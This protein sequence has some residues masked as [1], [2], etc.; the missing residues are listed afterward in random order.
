MLLWLESVET[1][2]INGTKTL[3]AILLH[4]VAFLIVYDFGVESV[5]FRMTEFSGPHEVHVPPTFNF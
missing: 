1:S 4:G 5:L 3:E 2:N